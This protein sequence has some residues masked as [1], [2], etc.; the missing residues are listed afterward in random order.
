MTNKASFKQKT[1]NKTSKGIPEIYTQSLN[2]K[3]NQITFPLA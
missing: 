2:C 3:V 1:N